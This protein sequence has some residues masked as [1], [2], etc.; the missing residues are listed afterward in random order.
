MLPWC[1]TCIIC[2]WGS[3]RNV[4][5]LCNNKYLGSAKWGCWWWRWR[6]PDFCNGWPIHQ[7]N[8]ERCC[9]SYFL[10]V[11]SFTLHSNLLVSS[12]AM[13]EYV[14]EILSTMYC[15]RYIL[16]LSLSVVCLRH[17]FL[18]FRML[19]VKSGTWASILKEKEIF[20]IM[21]QI[22]HNTLANNPRLLFE[23]LKSRRMILF[24]LFI[25]KKCLIFI[26]AMYSSGE[27]Y[28]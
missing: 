23:V 22:L 7:T 25:A 4:S 20:G 3:K 13:Y 11:S 27:M 1:N 9:C 15:I 16:L 14:A 6:N 2:R 10:Q 24:V 21:I 19:C 8:G 28:G 17:E 5:C 26:S 18:E 12:T